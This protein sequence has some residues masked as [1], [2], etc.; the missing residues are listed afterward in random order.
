MSM[1]WLIAQS[2]MFDNI[3]SITRQRAPY[4]ESPSRVMASRPAVSVGR[5]PGSRPLSGLSRENLYLGTASRRLV[6]GR[7]ARHE[8]GREGFSQRDVGSIVGREVCT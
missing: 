5:P 4:L 2:T 8:R 7:I 1:K 3:D 6:Q